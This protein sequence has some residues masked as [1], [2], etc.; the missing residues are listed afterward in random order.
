MASVTSAITPVI[1]VN[2]IVFQQ[3]VRK[4][5]HNRAVQ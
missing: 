4:A 1:G 3:H 5:D 2:I